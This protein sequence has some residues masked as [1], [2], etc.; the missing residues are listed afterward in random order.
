MTA[1]QTNFAALAVGSSGANAQITLGS[2]NI[3]IVVGIDKS[4]IDATDFIF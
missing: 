3:I 4:Q 1:L 2:N